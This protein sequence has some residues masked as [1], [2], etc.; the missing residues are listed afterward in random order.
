MKR[1]KHCSDSRI[2]YGQQNSSDHYSFYNIINRISDSINYDSD[3]NQNKY[4][5]INPKK[6]AHGCTPF[7]NRNKRSFYVSY[8]FNVSRI[9]S[10]A[11]FTSVSHSIK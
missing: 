10:Q 5:C 8:M 3:V 4:S 1:H 2:G 9:V 11:F 6:Y 7:L